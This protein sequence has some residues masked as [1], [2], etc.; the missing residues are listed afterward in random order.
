[1]RQACPGSA[2]GHSV[3]AMAQAATAMRMHDSKLEKLEL[4][5]SSPTACN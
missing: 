1:L 2:P 5:V 3:R 4:R